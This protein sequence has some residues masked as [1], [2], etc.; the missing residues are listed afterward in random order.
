VTTEFVI[1]RVL[2]AP[3][4]L[5]F[6]CL[7]M[8]EN[9]THFWGPVGTT[10]PLEHITVDLRPG[11]AFETVMVNDVTGERYATHCVFTQIDP[12]ETIAWRDL[13]HGMISTTT[14]TE[15]DDR[16]TE[17]RIQQTN[18]PDAFATPEARAG[19]G[20]SLDR[21]ASYLATFA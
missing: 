18:A 11:G 9:L 13:D 12:P 15:L 19:F 10:T 20:T 2:N 4:Q 21:L 1:T 16:R 17:M 14:F 5:V 3:R 6:D 7:T 8:P